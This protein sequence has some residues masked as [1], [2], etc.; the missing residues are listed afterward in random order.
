MIYLLISNQS[1]LT[2]LVL[3][4]IGSI[5]SLLGAIKIEQH[6]TQNH[7][8]TSETFA[9]RFEVAFDRKL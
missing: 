2:P 5:A 6:G 4:P 9:H 8:L 1:S 7:T 3:D